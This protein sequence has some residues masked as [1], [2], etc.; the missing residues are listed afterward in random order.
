M[1]ARVR[2]DDLSRLPP[3][4]PPAGIIAAYSV[5]ELADAARA[6]LLTRLLDR[7]RRGDRV[8]IVE[9]LAR[10][11]APWWSE[12]RDAFACIGGPGDEWR[13]AAAPPPLLAKLHPAPRLAHRALPRRP[14]ITP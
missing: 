8:L 4:K 5:N 3:S 12:W 7:A 10:G 9:P 6:A 2:R 1:N 14:L 13:V 11:I